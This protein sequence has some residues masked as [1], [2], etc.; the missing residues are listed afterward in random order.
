VTSA[1]RDARAADDRGGAV[2]E[3]NP[4]LALAVVVGRPDD[5]RRLAAADVDT[6]GA[7]SL[8]RLGAR[9][10]LFRPPGGSFSATV[11]NAAEAFGE[12]IVLWSVDPADWQPGRDGASD[13][14]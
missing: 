4:G 7:Q 2:G 11:V 10:T 9:P 3:A 6:L 12:R 5:Q 13:R 8:S 14:P 1:A